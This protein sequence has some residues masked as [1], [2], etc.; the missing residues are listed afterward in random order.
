MSSSAAGSAQNIPEEI[1]H[2][3]AYNLFR[4]LL[5]VISCHL[6]LSSFAAWPFLSLPF[7]RRF[8]AEFWTHPGRK[9]VL[10]GPRPIE[11][12]LLFHALCVIFGAIVEQRS[13]I[14]YLY[15][16]IYIYYRL[17]SVSGGGW[18]K[19]APTRGCVSPSEF[20]CS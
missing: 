9:T 2:R 4:R 6:L 3:K 19:S 17:F 15:I 7:K 16:Y 20:V 8:G 1:N 18:P 10:K 12:V 11:R 14:I 13:F 5:C